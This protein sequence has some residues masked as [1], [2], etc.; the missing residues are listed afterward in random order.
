MTSIGIL[1]KQ[2]KKIEEKTSERNGRVDEVCHM[3]LT[4]FADKKEKSFVRSQALNMRLY[5]SHYRRYTKEC[6]NVQCKNRKIATDNFFKCSKC[7]M[8]YYCSRRCDKRDWNAY[9]RNNCQKL[10]KLC[11]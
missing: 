9:H 3:I 6:N 10:Q 11:L 2:C 8:V 1:R 4:V 7:K 5:H